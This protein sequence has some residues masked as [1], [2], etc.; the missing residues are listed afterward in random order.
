M[1]AAVYLVSILF[2][3]TAV[4][5]SLEQAADDLC[6]HVKAC[7]MAQISQEDMTPEVRQMMEPMLSNMCV[8]MRGQIE[9]VP[10]GHAL[11]QPAVE[12][13]RSMEA[14]SCDQMADGDSMHTD[15]CKEYEDLAKSYSPSGQ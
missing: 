9:T 13:M 6:E 8:S 14:I 5:D 12:C 4:A 10:T 15:T 11:Y 1:K 2:A 7:A 3:A